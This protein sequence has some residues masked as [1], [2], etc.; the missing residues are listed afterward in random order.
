MVLILSVIIILAAVFIY[1]LVHSLLASLRLKAL[2]RSWL[3][4]YAERGY[5][6]AYNIFAVITLI[7]VITLPFVLPD[8]T[9]YAIPLPWSILTTSMQLLAAF[10]LFIGLLQTGLWSFIGFSQLTSPQPDKQQPLV[11]KG[12]YRWVRHPLY[13]AGLA[14]IWLL[15]VMTVNLLALNIGLSAYLFIGALVEERKLVQIY[16]EGA[17]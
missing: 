9:L 11:L 17:A 6:L 5:R 1:S 7:P 3:G 8:K 14:F 15:P 10:V 13:T 12:L 4:S 16:G 2:V